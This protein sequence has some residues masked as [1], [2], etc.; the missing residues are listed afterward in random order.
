MGPPFL[1]GDSIAFLV[2]L[3]KYNQNMLIMR[4]TTGKSST[5]PARY[6]DHLV[7]GRNSKLPT[8]PK[9][10]SY[11]PDSGRLSAL[12]TVRMVEQARSA[13]LMLFSL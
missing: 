5:V 10:V 1:L 13:F 7:R 3:I 2:E 11:R 12:E 4:V 6:S 9:R 8:L